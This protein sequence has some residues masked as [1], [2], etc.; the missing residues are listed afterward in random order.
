MSPRSAPPERVKTIQDYVGSPPLLI[1][2]F[3]VLG[4]A[5]DDRELGARS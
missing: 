2:C 3:I 4:P 5:P 1:S